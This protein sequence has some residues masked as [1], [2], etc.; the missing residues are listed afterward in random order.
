[1]K[2]Y[3][4]ITADTPKALEKLIDDFLFLGWQLQGGVSVSL[5]ETDEFRYIEFAQAITLEFKQSDFSIV[6]GAGAE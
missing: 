3:K 1:M 5:S 4:I 6:G 2:K